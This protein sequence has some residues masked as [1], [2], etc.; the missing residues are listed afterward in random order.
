[1]FWKHFSLGLILFFLSF[2]TYAQESSCDFADF[3]VVTTP[4]PPQVSRSVRVIKE[5]LAQVAPADVI[6]IGDSLVQRWPLDSLEQ[7][8]G[9][10]S[11]ANFGVGS[12]R[13]QNVLWRLPAIR[14]I[15]PSPERIVLWIGSNNL[16]SEDK[17]CAIVAGIASLISE[18]HRLWPASALLVIGVI[19]RGQNYLMRDEDRAAV[20]S[21]LR[22]AQFSLGFRFIDPSNELRCS[23]EQSV[24]EGIMNILA[25]RI[26][27]ENYMPDN[28]HLS[29]KG[30]AIVERSVKRLR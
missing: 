5:Q 7:T 21:T 29:D 24:K 12:D 13:T 3:E 22:M 23:N 2:P 14:R 11:I 10:G 30:Y 25:Y 4:I 6:M 19:P 15:Q 16:V 1:M 8:F 27:C 9:T 17:R 28:I 20:N 26:Y 18:V